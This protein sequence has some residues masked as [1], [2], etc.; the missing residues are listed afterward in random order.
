M[1]ILFCSDPLDSKVIDQEYEQEY[2]C[3]RNLGMDVHMISLES[4]LDGELSKA[5]KRIPTFETLE[6]FIYRGWML[7]PKDYENLYNAL[8]QKN[9]VLI[10]SPAEYRNGHYFPYS[11]EAIKKA[12]PQSMWLGIE[13][14][15]N[16]FDLLFKKLH[17]FQNKPIL[18]KD[19]VKSRKHEWEEACYIPDAS[20]RQKVQTVLQNFIDRQGSELNGGIVIREFI[21][22]EQLANH[23]KSGMPLSNEYRL[24]FLHH[25]LIQCTGY[26]DEVVYQQEIP[27]LDSFIDLAKG[28]ASPFFT[29]DIAKTTNGEWTIIEIG[30][31]QVSGL[32]SH[33]D[34]EQF[35][36]SI[37]E[38]EVNRL[39]RQ[40]LIGRI[41][42]VAF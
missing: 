30:D 40:L 31:G 22:L 35:Y 20:D 18:V 10:N 2:K 33:A 6:R 8:Q 12:T 19:Y 32:P 24:F 21:Q 1:K 11:Y 25:K 3:A 27:K 38:L 13:E 9:A 29:M 4:V 41:N 26:W 39:R 23:P 15:S 28:V 5:V 36:K 17:I 42:P 7:K 14:L 37:M 16:G 34:L